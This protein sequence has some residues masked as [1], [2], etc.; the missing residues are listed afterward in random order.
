MR[1]V[2]DIIM[3]A[4]QHVPKFNP[5]SIT[6]Y[7]AREAGANAEQEIAFT[8][9]AAIEY[10]RT[11]LQR[12]VPVD[13]FAPQ[14]SFHFASVR[15]LFE[16]ICKVRAARRMWARLMRDQFGARD[17][18]SMALR[19]FCG[20]AGT[21]MSPAEPLNNIVRSTIQCLVG[22]LAGAQAIHVQSYDEPY[23]IPSEEAVQISIRT[24]QIIAYESGAADVIDP[25]GGSYYVEWLTNQLEGRA[26]TLIDQIEASGGMVAA[27][28]QGIPQ[29]LILEQA[30]DMEREFNSGKRIV[31]GENTFAVEGKSAADWMPPLPPNDPSVGRRQVERLNHVRAERD[32]RLANE[33]LEALRQAASGEENL[34]DYILASVRAYASVGEICD[35]LRSEFGEYNPPSFL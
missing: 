16:E 23:T 6:G 32:A 24:Q 17:P 28:E 9:A 33:R 2:S 8:M 30:Y 34:M 10:V 27:I 21:A 4:Y 20:C 25:L 22:V 14:L 3:F 29:R 1:L 7:H 13:D 5:I 31:V 12:G 18:R 35:V 15:N 11:M 19:W 26:Q